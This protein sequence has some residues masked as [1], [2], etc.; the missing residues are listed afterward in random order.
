MADR[1]PP[2]RA[3]RPPVPRLPATRAARLLWALAALVALALAGVTLVSALRARD[4]GPTE[5]AQYILDVNVVMRSSALT[6]RDVNRSYGRFRSD[7][8]SV[9]TGELAQAERSLRGVRARLAAVPAPPATERLRQA[10]LQLLDGQVDFAHEVVLLGAYLPRAEEAERELQR[11]T[12]RLRQGVARAGT[13]GA[14][15][16]AFD[17]YAAAAAELAR[18]LRAAAP[19]ASFEDARD[20]EADRIEELGASAASLAAG[21][22]KLRAAEVNDA[23]DRFAAASTGNE[24]ARERRRAL[25]LYDR[26]LR[27]LASLQRTVERERQALEAQ[28]A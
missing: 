20:A 26:R 4:G 2:S 5:T 25:L 27:E 9:D 3:R 6:I 17:R 12:T 19:P 24:V 28:G 7:P 14:Q 10:L 16:A 22:R 1:P 21:L 15:G 8:A 13:I 11:A 23:L 18:D